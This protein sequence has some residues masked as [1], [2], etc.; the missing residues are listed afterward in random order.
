MSSTQQV[1]VPE[2]YARLVS[3]E[4]AEFLIELRYANIS[5]VLRSMLQGN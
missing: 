1:A 3:K 4:G 5:P 2:G